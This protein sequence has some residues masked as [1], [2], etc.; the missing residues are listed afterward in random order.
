M[1]ETMRI[2][3]LR[4]AVGTGLVAI[5]LFSC[6]S[7]TAHTEQRPAFLAFGIAFLAISIMTGILGFTQ[8]SQ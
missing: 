8:K 2:I 5:V 7:S 6:M 1:E 3:V 4:I